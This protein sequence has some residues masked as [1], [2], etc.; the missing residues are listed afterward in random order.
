MGWTSYPAT[1]FNN[2]GSIN[3]KA[4]CDSYFEEGLNRGYYKIEKSAIKGSTYYAAVTVL[5]TPK[6]NPDGTEALDEFGHC[7]YEPIPKNEQE[8]FGIVM[9]T[10]VKDG[11]FAYKPISESMGPCEHKCPK[12]VLDALSPTTNEYALEW[13][14]ACLEYLMK[15]NPSKLPV[16]TRIQFERNGQIVELVKRP[17]MYQFKTDWWYNADSGC[18]F[19]KKRLPEDFVVI[20]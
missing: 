13:R 5:L 14:Q 17:P 9:L 2:D 11:E 12:S 18:Y 6:K 8:T 19:S 3:R 7:I 15:P 20:T 1:K 16:G 4:E 10:G